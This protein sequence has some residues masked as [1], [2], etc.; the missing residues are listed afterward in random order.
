[1]TTAG[2][3]EMGWRVVVDEVASKRA[4]PTEGTP[5]LSSRDRLKAVGDGDA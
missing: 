2:L 3:A 1:M 5:R 4:E